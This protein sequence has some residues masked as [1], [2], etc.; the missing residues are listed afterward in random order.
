MWHG[1]FVHE[2][3]EDTRSLRLEAQMEKE[4]ILKQGGYILVL[5]FKNDVRDMKRPHFSFPRLCLGMPFCRA[6][7]G[8]P[9]DFIIRAQNSG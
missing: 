1:N 5:H 7:P 8:Y 4:L 2:G 3:H 9:R 6:L